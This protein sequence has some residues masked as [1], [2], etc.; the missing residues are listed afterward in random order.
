LD[1]GTHQNAIEMPLLL[2]RIIHIHRCERFCVIVLLLV[3][4]FIQQ[5]DRRVY[6]QCCA[7]A[8]LLT[9]VLTALTSLTGQPAEVAE[10]VPEWGTMHE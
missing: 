5:F 1:A 10:Q 9:L 7:A 2:H 6:K 4:E 3:R 8:S